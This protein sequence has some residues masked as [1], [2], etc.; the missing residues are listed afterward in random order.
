MSKLYINFRTFLITALAATAAVLCAYCYLYSR[1]AGLA[2]GIICCIL[3]L[4]AAVIGVILF[5]INRIRLA[6]AITFV[7]ASV[8]G[9]CAFSSGIFIADNWR[10]GQSYAG[11]R[12]VTARV[13]AIDVHTGKYM[14]DLDELMLD[15]KRIN[16]ILRLDI[17]VS[18]DNIAELIDSGDR[19]QFGARLRAIELADNGGVNGAA[20]RTDIRYIANVESKDIV[21]DFGKPKPLESLNNAMRKLLTDGM[22]EKYGN[23]A[24]SM[25]TGDKYS[26]NTG[27]F[28]YFSAAGIGHI[29]AV[30]GLHIG[31]FVIILNMLLFKLNKRVRFPIIGVVLIAYA[32][33]ADFSPSVV[34]A[35]IMT[36]V[37]GIGTLI[38]GRRDLLSSLMCAYSLILA[39]KPFYIFEA[40]FLLSFGALYGIAM[41]S[42]SLLRMALKRKIPRKLCNSACGS[43]SA[44]LGILP[45]EAYFFGTVH[46]LAFL[47]NMVII[48]YVTVVFISIVLAMPVAAIQ[49]CLPVLGICKF[50]L[51]P[52]DYI[53]ILVAN[54][55]NIVFRLQSCGAVLLCYPLFFMAS[56]YVIADRGMAT[57]GIYSFLACAAI[58][59]ACAL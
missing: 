2:L 3:L 36:F 40:G 29:M 18:D 41:F 56:E 6:I 22:G 46:S 30:S 34:R 38:G 21:V 45:A 26:L 42:G 35:I 28:D 52:L 7:L 5:V 8:I 47:V 44:S 49:G 17:A 59:I 16:G 32:I 1:S 4:A 54:T 27:V 23:I 51:I 15:G 14:V 24:F 13:C 39:V 10:D 11:Y 48:P 53:A 31:F 57:K 55:P 37:A 58:I 43:I 9:I 33:I 19:V 50:L 25:L 20:Y 12:A